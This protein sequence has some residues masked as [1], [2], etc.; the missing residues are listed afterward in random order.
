MKSYTFYYDYEQDSIISEDAT[1]S[2]TELAITYTVTNGAVMIQSVKVNTYGEKQID[3]IPI[4][5]VINHKQLRWM[6]EMDVERR[7]Q[8]Q[9][10]N[11]YPLI[12]EQ[13][14]FDKI[15]EAL[16]LK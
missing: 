1:N 4:L 10:Y 12:Y 3:M 2:S 8:Q 16:K 7:N 14:R 6:A 9:I 15:L 11:N 5:D 13:M